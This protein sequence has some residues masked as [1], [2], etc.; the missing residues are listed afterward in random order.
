MRFLVWANETLEDFL[1]SH[2]WQTNGSIYEVLQKK[3]K[4]S[5][6][7]VYEWHNNF[8]RMCTELEGHLSQQ[9]FHLHDEELQRW[10]KAYT[11]RPETNAPTIEVVGT[12]AEQEYAWALFEW[13]KLGVRYDEARTELQAINQ[14][15]EHLEDCLVDK[16]KYLLTVVKAYERMTKKRVN[17]S[18]E[19][20]FHSIV[21]SVHWHVTNGKLQVNS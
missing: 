20:I 19:S 16:K 14:R 9:G 3:L 12:R 5:I 13:K 18:E 17:V 4:H 1:M 6:A 8:V 2:T 21:S 11:T 15:G 7:H 10:V